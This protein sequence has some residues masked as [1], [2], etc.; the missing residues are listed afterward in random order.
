MKTGRTTNATKMMTAGALSA[1][2]SRRANQP[3]PRGRRRTSPDGGNAEA[4]PPSVE[5]FTGELTATGA[6]SRVESVM[7]LALSPSQRRRWPP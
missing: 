3:A 6:F 4:L 7:V 1:A 2:I 5:R